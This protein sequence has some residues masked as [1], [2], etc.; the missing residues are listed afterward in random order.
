[1]MPD[2]AMSSV[3]ILQTFSAVL[4]CVWLSACGEET[5]ST[6]APPAAPRVTLSA[7]STDITTRTATTLA[8]NSTEGS[9]IFF[10]DFPGTA[11]DSAKWAV[12]N[13]LS[14]QANNELNC[15]IPENISVQNGIL[16]GVSRFEDRV[17]GDSINAPKIMHYTS[18]QIQQATAPFLYGTI[19]VRAKVPGGSGIWPAVFMLGFEWQASQPFTANTLGHNWPV[20]GWCEVDIAEFLNNARNKV[21]NVVHYNRAG[22]TNLRALPFNANTRFMVYRFQWTANSLIWSVDAEDGVGYRTLSTITDPSRIPNVPMYLTINAAIGGIGGGTPD[23]N[24][25]PQTFQVDYVRVTQKTQ[26][27]LRQ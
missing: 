8:L 2:I 10:D 3:P 1:M 27:R 17:C 4:L 21:N 9:V 22:G 12:V 7:Q 11:I 25:F 19:E 16:S 23:R 13:R 5:K 14:D 26:S 6:P 15:V 20:G 24:T 18:W